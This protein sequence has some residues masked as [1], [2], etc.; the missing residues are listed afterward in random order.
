MHITIGSMNRNGTIPFEVLSAAQN[1]GRVVLQTKKTFDKL[2]D[3]SYLT[4]DKIYEDAEDFDELALKACEFL[5]EDGT[6]FICL[7]DACQSS[8][9]VKLVSAVIEGGG[10]ISVIPYGSEAEA[11]ALESGIIRS[12]TGITVF[13][14]SSFESATNTDNILIIEEIDNRTFASELKLKLSRYYDDEHEVLFINTNKHTFKKMQLFELDGEKD[15]G[16][17]CSVAIA[18]AE[19]EEKK[20]YTFLD[21]V[22]VM[23]KLRSRNGCPWD[24]EQTHESLKKYLIEESYEVLEAIDD[25]DMNALYDELGDVM[26]QIVFHAKI[27]QQSSEFD[28]SDIT[29]AICEKMISRHSHIFGSAV[30][31]TPGDV[32][33][34]WEVI[35]KQEKNH[36]SQTDVLKSVPKSMPAL[37]RSGKVQHKAAHIGFDF[38]Q[39]E[40][41][42]EKLREEICEIEQDL[43]EGNDPAEECGDLLFSVVNVVRLLGIDPEITLQNATDKFIKRFEYVEKLASQRKIDMKKSSLEVLDAL[44]NEAKKA[45]D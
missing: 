21:L 7:G 1:A 44:W 6:L 11:L 45:A 35:K 30:A 40:Q 29:S 19:L 15:Y 28:I 41:A 14:A 36:D 4:L 3:T 31:H 12:T 8:I 32:I 2:P 5:M 17:Y 18:P 26:L 22:K 16:Y 43:T 9:A 33:K 13:T 37:L 24:K 39:A 25:N 10:T 27:A 20:R 38:E 34:N 23:D 42:I